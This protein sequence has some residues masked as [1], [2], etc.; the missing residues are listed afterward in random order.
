MLADGSCVYCR[1]RPIGLLCVALLACDDPASDDLPDPDVGTV[2]DAAWDVPDPDAGHGEPDDGPWPDARQPDF[3]PLDAVPPDVQDPDAMPPDAGPDMQPDD[4]RFRFPRRP[5]CEGSYAPAVELAQLPAALVEVSGLATSPTRDDVVWAHN[6]SGDGPVLYAMRDDGDLLGRLVLDVDAVDWED[7]AAAPCPDGLSP[8]LW[9]AD[10]GNN[11]RDRDELVVYAVPEPDVSEPFGDLAADALW[12]F[13]V[14][15]PD[16]VLDA[17]AL[18]V[19]RDGSTFWLFEKVDGPQARL[20]RHPGPLA[21][22]TSETLLEVGA[23]QTPGVPIRRGLMIT[24]ADLHPSGT[25]L[26]LRVYTGSYEY[27]FDAGGGPDDVPDVEPR[28]VSLGPLSEG[29]GEAITYSADGTAVL[30]A[31]ED[32]SFQAA[33]PLHIYRCQDE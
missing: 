2:V 16:E 18:V 8:C 10:V 22:G 17:E 25:R 13:P 9:V 7:L 15:Y 32:P 6:D 5:T 3:A 30:T 14:R 27:R 33:Q 21:D 26:L 1:V 20:F 4:G 11:L 23:L 24:G 12:R 29:Q 28:V 31:S 19:A